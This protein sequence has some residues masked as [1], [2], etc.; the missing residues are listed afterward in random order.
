MKGNDGGGG[1]CC[2]GSGGVGGDGVLVMSDNSPTTLITIAPVSILRPA[3][4]H[5]LSFGGI[6][7]SIKY[8]R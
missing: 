8:Q 2:S 4:Q 1:G 3:A 5:F 7:F 6:F